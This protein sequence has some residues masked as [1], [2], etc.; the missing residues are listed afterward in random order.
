MKEKNTVFR[1]DK[2]FQFTELNS[3]EDLPFP[4][5]RKRIFHWNKMHCT[6]YFILY[7]IM[8]IV[9]FT[10]S[11][12]AIQCNNNNNNSIPFDEDVDFCT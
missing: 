7:T 6:F 10:D 5:E 2:C 8:C 1:L 9:S 3:Y 11:S 12:G 4:F